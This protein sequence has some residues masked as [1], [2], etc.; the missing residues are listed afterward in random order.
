MFV[1]CGWKPGK[2]SL[3]YQRITGRDQIQFL[4]LG[5]V[6]PPTNHPHTDTAS[7]SF[8]TTSVVGSAAMKQLT[9][10]AATSLLGVS[11]AVM[12]TVNL[13]EKVPAGSYV[14]AGGSEIAVWLYPPATSDP[15]TYAHLPIV[16]PSVTGTVG[17]D[18]YV[19][20]QLDCTPNFMAQVPNPPAPFRLNDGIEDSHLV[21]SSEFQFTIAGTQAVSPSTMSPETKVIVS[22]SSIP[23]G[24][25]R[26]DLD[27][28]TMVEKM[29]PLRDATGSAR[30]QGVLVTV[31]FNS[32]MVSCGALGG[33]GA[34]DY[35]VNV[36]CVPVATTVP[37]PKSGW[38]AINL[39]CNEGFLT[40]V[41]YAVFVTN[42]G[43]PNCLGFE[44]ATQVVWLVIGWGGSITWNAGKETIKTSPGGSLVAVEICALDAGC[45]DPNSSHALSGFVFYPAPD[46][47]A[48]MNFSTPAA[49]PFVG[50]QDG[51]YGMVFDPL[52]GTWYSYAGLPAWWN[53][54]AAH[55][56]GATQI[57][58]PAPESLAALDQ[59]APRPT[60]TAKC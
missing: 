35:S 1:I 39:N 51:C 6:Q 15:C 14:S 55:P 22:G 60:V 12:V 19:T 7:Y 52:V 59:P 27:L 21:S 57:P 9:A 2:Q 30:T 18:P 5:A 37:A 29:L 45:A 34:G 58:A 49:P 42:F 33:G 26:N 38:S 20:L 41:G 48:V 54:S 16:F 8:A 4:V 47:T 17:L 28:L 40:S 44:S 43:V 25:G 3:T 50:L 10:K 24:S 56:V 53:L 11:N 23:L 32:P 31:S 13:R 46:G 36:N